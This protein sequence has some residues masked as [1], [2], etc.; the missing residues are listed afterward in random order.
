[1]TNVYRQRYKGRHKPSNGK[2]HF[3]LHL[4]DCCYLFSSGLTKALL[5]LDEI[6]SSSASNRL[7]IDMALKEWPQKA[8][9]AIE[10]L[11]NDVKDLKREILF[12]RDMVRYF[13]IRTC[14]LNY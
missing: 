10:I 13:H 1:M 3:L 11:Q 4:D 12:L 5:L 7:E 9:G 14:H 6:Y 8:R 2:L